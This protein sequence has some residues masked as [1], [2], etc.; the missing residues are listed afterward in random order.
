MNLRRIGA[1]FRKEMHHIVR[2]SR[3]LGMALAVPLLL[4]L[5]FGYALS[6]DVDRIPTLVYDLNRTAMSRQLIRRTSKAPAISTFEV[7]S[8]TTRP[9][10][11]ES[12]A[13]RF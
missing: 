11:R 6:L 7:M 1:M 10:S 3:S 8:T 5:L 13:G 2:D 12:I 9:S 4:L